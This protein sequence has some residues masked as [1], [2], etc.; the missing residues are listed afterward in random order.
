MQ[1]LALYK[2]VE[3]RATLDR[4]LEEAEGEL[5]PE[6]EEM[7]DA[8]DGRVDEKIERIGLYIRERGAAA[9]AVKEERDR[10]DALAK[11][12]ERAAESLKGYVKRH[13]EAL[14]KTKVH[15]LLATVAIQ[16]NSQPSVTTSLAPAELYAEPASRPFV[17]REET[18]LYSLDREAVLAV[19]KRHE[20]LPETIVVD[21]GSHIRVR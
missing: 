19:W 12:E 4:V 14:G 17:H 18:V 5:T 21:L 2:L 16:H 3:I 15:G 20:P 10:L 6:V 8:L 9:K 1:N 13:M 11:R 7:L